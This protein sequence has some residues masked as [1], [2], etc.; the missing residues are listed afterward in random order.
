MQELSVFVSECRCGRTF[1]TI[2]REYVCPA[3]NRHIRL[4]WG[5]DPAVERQADSSERS[6]TEAT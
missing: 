6:T 1:E 3:C 2:N 5:Q 4:E